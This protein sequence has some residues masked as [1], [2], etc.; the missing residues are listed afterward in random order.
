MLFFVCPQ[1]LEDV[2]SGKVDVVFNGH[3]HAYERSYPV[4]HDTVTPAS[5]GGVTYITIGDGG[6]R[7]GFA[8][9]W[10]DPQPEWS[11]VR[12][13]AY[14]FGE[15]TVHNRTTATWRWLRNDQPGTVGDEFVF[16]K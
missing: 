16:Q 15:F 14:G 11:A 4:L 2:V 8:V 7:E 3:V 9:P 13:C 6:N 10:V 1:D 5:A 12:E